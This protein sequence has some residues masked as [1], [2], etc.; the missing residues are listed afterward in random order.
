MTGI[1]FVTLDGG[2]NLPPTLGIAA[3]LQHRGS[4]V[5]F[6]GHQVQRAQI[7]P[8]GFSFAT[9]D[10]GMEYDA[11][12]PRSTFTGVRDVSRLGLATDVIAAARCERTD[13][14]IIDALLYRAILESEK[15]H[16]PVVQLVHSFSG[17]FDRFAK[18]PFG[19]ICRMRGADPS[20]ALRAPAL[21]L[22]T[23][24]SDL[25]PYRLATMRHTGL[26][27]QGQPVA[28]VP[29]SPA[30]I[31]VSFSTTA[32]PGQA[33]AL[34]RTV[35]GLGALEADVT[36][37]TGPS[38]DPATIR[39]A[40]N[41]SV[42]RFID[43]GELLPHTSLVISHGGHAT[44]ARALSYGVPLLVL[45]MHRLL[46]QAMVGA[47]LETHGVGLS[48]S[49]RS[50]ASAIGEAASR[51]LADPGVR[52]RAAALGE[53]IRVQDGAVVAADLV[54]EFIAHRVGAR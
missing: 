13:V 39:P 19:T 49:K 18:G 5:R 14:V 51:L 29:A 6:L 30:R 33:A 47:A 38:I 35:D 34:Q 52:S 17:Y 1:L 22:V 40:G 45:P 54:E 44:V 11:A 28:A 42:R 48:I 3:E 21:S 7:E 36:V 41:T 37:T 20:D 43:H 27:W 16:L 9:Y 25:D 12:Q 53:D 32:F 10:R 23:T 24:R 50:S 15:E 2:G 4:A 26:V 8:R 31:L 46:D